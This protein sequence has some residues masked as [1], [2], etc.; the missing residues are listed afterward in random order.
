MG[1]AETLGVRVMELN[2]AG[3]SWS[4]QNIRVPVNDYHCSDKDGPCAVVRLRVGVQGTEKAY[5][6]RPWATARPLE[7]DP[8]RKTARTVTLSYSIRGAIQP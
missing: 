5:Q 3:E 1:R 8:W 4:S 6:A 7:E 2:Q